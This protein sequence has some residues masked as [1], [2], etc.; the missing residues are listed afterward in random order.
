ML[1][2]ALV[3]LVIGLIAGLLG[4]TG[5]AI[6]L[7]DHDMDL[8]MNVCDELVVLER[9]ADEALAPAEVHLARFPGRPVDLVIAAGVHQQRR[10][11]PAHRRPRHQWT[12]RD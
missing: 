7:V 2:W 1:R 10:G 11:S 9:L 5:V 8:V 4:F 12:P 6:L 3:F